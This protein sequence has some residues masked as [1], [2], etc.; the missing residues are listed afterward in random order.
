[1]KGHKIHF[2]GEMWKIIPKIPLLPLHIWST[3][4]SAYEPP[5]LDIHCSQILVFCTF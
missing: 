1:M 3:D 5:H 4:Y 2:N